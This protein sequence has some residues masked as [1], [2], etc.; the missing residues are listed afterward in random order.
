L[1]WQ[2][3]AALPED[4]FE[5]RVEQAKARVEGVTISA[6]PGAHRTGYTGNYEWHTPAEYIEMARGVLG[7]IDLDPASADE[8]QATAGRRRWSQ[9]AAEEIRLGCGILR[10]VLL[11]AVDSSGGFFSLCG[12]VHD[13]VSNRALV[14]SER[15][16]DLPVGKVGLKFLDAI[17]DRLAFGGVRRG[18]GG[19]KIC[20]AIA[21]LPCSEC[22]CVRWVRNF[23]EAASLSAPG[24]LLLAATSGRSPRPRG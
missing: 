8:A 5:I 4:K 24:L 20:G 15:A 22:A 1:R 17:D 3:L 2:K 10:T 21:S 13:I 9:L 12:I 16:G 18:G 14:H 7:G 11:R 6:V 19:R 23:A